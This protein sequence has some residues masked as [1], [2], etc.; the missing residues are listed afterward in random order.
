M[1]IKKIVGILFGVV[2]LSMTSACSVIME[3]KEV[4]VLIPEYTLDT[5]PSGVFVKNGDKFYSPSKGNKTYTNTPENSTPDRV[6]WYTDDKIH[7]P[8]YKIGDEIIY[9]DDNQIPQQF[10]LEGFEHVCDSFGIRSIRMN[11]AGKYIISGTSCLN[12]TS[13][14]SIKLNELAKRSTIIVDNI[15]DQS[16]NSRMINKTG[17]ISGLEKG[18]LYTLGFYIGTQY[19][20]VDIKA[21]TEIYVSKSINTITDYTLT[22]KGYM[23]LKMPEMLT[24]GLYDINNKGIVN[25]SGLLKE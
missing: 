1:N 9:K 15:N 6:I 25:Y 10:V 7:V 2:V 13:D 5:L 18:K 8:T 23:T 4:E 12:P 21:D 17:S 24:P 16:I 19:Y 14:A 20:E 3:P 11:D 22:K